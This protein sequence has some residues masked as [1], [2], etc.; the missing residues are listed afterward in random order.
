MEPLP[1]PARERGDRDDGVARRRELGARATP[2]GHA[3]ESK[4]RG[5]PSGGAMTLEV[6]G[7]EHGDERRRRLRTGYGGNG[8]QRGRERETMSRRWPGSP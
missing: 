1:G 5:G 4:R 3:F 6:A 2:R 8:L 7:V